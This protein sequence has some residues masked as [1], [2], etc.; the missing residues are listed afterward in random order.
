MFDRFNTMQPATDYWMSYVSACSQRD[1]RDLHDPAAHQKTRVISAGDKHLPLRVLSVIPQPSST[2]SMIF[3][4]R[5]VASLESAGVISHSFL[6]FSRTS[7]VAVVKEWIRLRHAIRSFQPHLVHAHYGTVTALLAGL[8]TA[9]PIVITYRGSD[10]NPSSS[11]WPRRF[12][13][14]LFSQMAALRAARI[15]CVS[16]QL[17]NRLWWRKK[18]AT[19]IPSGVNTSLF[20]PRPRE[21][22]REELSWHQGEKVVLFNAGDPVVKRLDLARAA[23]KFAERLCGTIRLFTLDGNVPPKLIP[24]IMNAADCLLVTSDW[25]GSP[26]VVKESLACNLPVVSVDVGDVRERLSGVTPSAVVSKDPQ[27]IG[28]S[29]ADI[30]QQGR[31]SNGREFVS[32]F[33][34]ETIS[35][36]ILSLYGEVHRSKSLLPKNST[37]SWRSPVAPAPSSQRLTL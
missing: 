28:A 1:E 26:N 36:Q 16:K 24:T 2:A 15:I 22:A 21:A 23:I 35:S 14:R 25:E 34:S 4:M 29:L 13:S 27:Q 10:L 37:D 11:S 5:Q 33:S 20:Y 8:S 30:L 12:L 31:R 7:P 32:A 3:A 18:R 6:L 19:V 9:K 17:K